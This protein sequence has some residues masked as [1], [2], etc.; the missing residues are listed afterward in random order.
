MR[1]IHHAAPPRKPLAR[2][3]RNLCLT[4]PARTTSTPRTT[5][6]TVRRETVAIR[7]AVKKHLRDAV[8]LD[9]WLGD[10]YQDMPEV[11]DRN[12]RAVLRS[13]GEAI[14]EAAA[15]RKEGLPM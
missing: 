3:T 11:I 15:S 2:K 7:K 12:F 1:R 10:F 9:K 4:R 13:Y 8:D 6:R 5:S 14:Q